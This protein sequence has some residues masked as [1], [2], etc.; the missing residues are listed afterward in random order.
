MRLARFSHGKKVGY[1][2]IDDDGDG[3]FEISAED[4][5]GA[6]VAEPQQGEFFKLEDL[7]LLAPVKPSKIVAIGL[8]YRAHAA[9]FKQDIP[10]EPL[11]FMKPST[12]VIGPDDEIVYP[13]HMSHRVDYEGE[14]AVVIGRRAKD[15][16]L[17]EA[18]SYILG[19]TAFNDVTA[20]DLQ[21]RDGQWTR[22]KGFDTF[23]PMGPWIETELE[24]GAVT[25]ET[26]LN[27][28]VRQK[29]STVDMIFNVSELVSFVSS[30]MTLLPGDVIATGT[31]SGVGK[32]K[33]G[34]RVEV[35]VQGIGSLKNTVV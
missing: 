9:E 5:F 6:S 11:F 29:T 34:D 24:A 35:R 12:T 14:L 17:T 30:V 33:P 7:R 2:V 3:L 26:F 27:G 23:A 32:M 25:I 21:G 20:R 22:A 1:A 19:Y 16:S 8:N 18:P 15:V 28:E 13:A 10:D 4:F 31:P